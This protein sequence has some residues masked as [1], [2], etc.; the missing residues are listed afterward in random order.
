MKIYYVWDITTKIYAGSVECKQGMN[1]SN[2]TELKPLPFKA[3][4]DIVW[5]GDAWEYQPMN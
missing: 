4:N 2:S 1:P 5:N 3:M